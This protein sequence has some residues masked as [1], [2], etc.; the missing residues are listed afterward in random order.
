MASLEEEFDKETDLAAAFDAEPEQVPAGSPL[1]KALGEQLGPVVTV[2][3]PTGPARFT[4]KG[5]PFVTPEEAMQ[6]MEGPALDF[7]RRV[8]EGILSTASG[9]PAYGRMG[10]AVSAGKALLAGQPMVEAYERGKR[11]VLTEAQRATALASPTVAGLPVLPIAGGA[12]ATAPAGAA[13]SMVGRLAMQAG[14]G[15]TS[16]TDVG[17][18]TAGEALTGAG[19]GLAFG[20][21]GEAASA[22]P[23]AAGRYLG[24]KAAAAA[25]RAQDVIQ[26]ARDKTVASERGMLGRIVATQSNAADTILDVLRNPGNY[27]AATVAQAQN[28]I[29]T[30][31]GQV[32]LNRAAINNI[33]KLG[34]AFGQEPAQRAALASAV[35]AAQPQ[36]VAA[37]AAQQ[38]APGAL[39]SDLVGRFGRSIG[40]RAALGAAG[41]GAAELLGVDEWKGGLLGATIAPGALQMLRNVA[42]A[43]KFQAGAFG[44]LESAA[45]GTAGG[46]R[47]AASV[48]GPAGI[49]AR[50]N[51][52]RALAE[53][54]GISPQSKEELADEAFIRGQTSP[55]LQPG[56]Q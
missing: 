45:T 15:A 23:A 29:A 1:A 56:R 31:E 28:V 50:N 14:L 36:A 52:F 9:S 12:L 46:I 51:A 30:S 22:I 26:A 33:A 41:A 43:P 44:A 32:M 37:E 3:T 24:D 40:Q 6:R 10:G 4:R 47:G 54:F 27:D 11:E 20:A 2:E 18:G 16:A 49:Q 17:R 8:L 13:P 19:L 21:A 48:S 38:L 25:Q 55:D 34:E 35:S 7:R 5:Q 39:A 42:K 53:R